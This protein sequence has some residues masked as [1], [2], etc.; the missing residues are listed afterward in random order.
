MEMDERDA[1]AIDDY[2]QGRAGINPVA[3][4][5]WPWRTQE[6]AALVDWMRRYNAPVPEFARVHFHGFDYQGERRDFRMAQNVF[7][8]LDQLGADTRVI[9]W[10]HNA[11]I[12]S[13]PGWMGS[14]LKN[15]LRN[16]IYLTGFEFH[17]GRFTSNLN[18]VRTYEAE[19]AGSGYYAAT[20][21][22]IGRPVLFLD[23]RTMQKDPGVNEWLSRPKFTHEL[24]ELHGLLRLNPAWVRTG[25]S[26]LSSFDGMVYIE[27]ST[28]ARLL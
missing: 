8:L 16:Q 5:Q 26:W 3:G 20:L 24:Q 11:H 27:E 18:W 15:R 10:A 21:E 2:I 28:P 25:E 12:S 1:R 4:L 6:I 7:T 14:Y 23:F 22:R 13:V 17:H 9:L 19:A